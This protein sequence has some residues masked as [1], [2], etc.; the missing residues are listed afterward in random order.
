MKHLKTFE[1]YNSEINE[2]F[3]G[4][5]WSKLTGLIKGKI[6]DP[7]LDQL[8]KDI[9][10]MTEE[11]KLNLIFKSLREIEDSTLSCSI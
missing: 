4:D 7:S 3:L 8:E 2:G 1:G 10:I 11:Q 6:D 5:I 9:N